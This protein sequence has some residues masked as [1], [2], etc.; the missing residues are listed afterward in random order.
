MNKF[1][2]LAVGILM[3][4]ALIGWKTTLNENLTAS[5]I[6]YVWVAEA[7]ALI[8]M[9]VNG[10]FVSSVWF[11]IAAFF[12]CLT[13]LGILFRI[14]HYPGGDELS[15]LPL[16]AVFILYLVHF[17]KKAAK[18]RV[19][20]LKV[21]MLLGA[22]VLAPIVFLHLVPVLERD[23]FFL[24]SHVLLWSTF[25]DFLYTGKQEGLLTK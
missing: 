6:K 9:L 12:L 22:L 13:A 20:Y 3:L 23:S 21:L 11:K 10:T 19:D 2:L 7:I 5:A 8:M 14:M 24:V 4:L 25:L 17:S 1:L 16:L 15:T 18:R